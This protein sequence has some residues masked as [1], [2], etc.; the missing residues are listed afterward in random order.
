MYGG[1]MATKDGVKL[2]E[3][4]CRFADPESMNVLTTLKNDFTQVALAA[5]QQNLHKIKLEFENKATVCK[6][7][8]PNGYPDNPTSG[9]K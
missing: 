6:Y 5:T 4:N 1:F 7:L 2:I 3:Y 9:Q 8:V